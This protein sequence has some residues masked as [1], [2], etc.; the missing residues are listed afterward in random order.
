MNAL[1]VVG[2]GL[3]STVQDRG[4]PGH[5]HLGVPLAG[6]VDPALAALV[7]RL[8]GNPDD[9]AVIETCGGLTV[10]AFGAALVATTTEGAARSIAPGGRVHVPAGHGRLWHYVAVRGGVVAETVLGS[11]STDT[12]SGLGPPPLA[13][14]DRLD[15]GDDP[16]TPVDGAAHAPLR[17]LATTARITPGPRADWFTPGALD[18]LTRS[19]WTLA[20]SSRV[21]VRLTGRAIERVRA[22][23]LASEGLVRGAIQVP[24]DGQ[25]VMML[26]DHPTTGGYPVLAV[27]H[28]EDVAVV[29]QRSAGDR[30][31]FRT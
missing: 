12:L 24:P 10:E 28:P 4:R 14:G 31:R 7:N 23:E 26:A 6:A 19:E 15:I 18:L 11:R 27:V 1:L 2:A 30:V 5:A 8:V 13:D 20:T 25:P 17:P 9:A 29:A 3:A 22:G 16:G 21:G